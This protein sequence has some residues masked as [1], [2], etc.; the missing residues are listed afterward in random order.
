AFR[1]AVSQKRL[2]NPLQDVLEHGQKL[3][4]DLIRPA[5]VLVSQAERILISPDGALHTLPFAA[6]ISQT[7]PKPH[8]FIE[9]KPLHTIVSMTVYT[10]TRKLAAANEAKLEP[11]LLAF[12][13]AI[14]AKEQTA[15]ATKQEQ[16]VQ[17]PRRSS[18]SE[19]ITNSDDPKAAYF[20]QR[21]LNLTP[22]PGTRKE[23][24]EIAELYGSAA[25][26]KLGQDV[27]KTAIREKSSNYS[28]LHFAVHGWFD[29]QI[30]LNSGLALSQP[31]AFGQKSEKSENGL[32]Q[33]W[34][35]LEQARLKADL[36]VLSACV[37]GLGQELR[38][39]GI[40][41]LTRAF[42]YAGAKSVVVSLWSVSDASTAKL[43]T[44]FHRE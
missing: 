44:A 23:V 42:H 10:E 2:G 28:I 5:Q 34:E 13:D 12:G 11:K 39:E 29:G 36:V 8:Y 33:A 37:T 17:A 3:Y 22:L 38:G 20:H 9:D 4:D 24:E 26:V 40:I 14:Y 21:G 43:M 19:K 27:T 41:G 35:M 1:D 18:E 16:A 32:W 6:L 7:K 15:A 30:G 31:E 25:T